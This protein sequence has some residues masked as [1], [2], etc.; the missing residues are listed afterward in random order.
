MAVANGGMH[1]IG[2]EIVN[3]VDHTA[4]ATLEDTGHEVVG[5]EYRADPIAMRLRILSDPLVHEQFLPRLPHLF[6]G[7]PVEPCR[8]MIGESP[9]EHYRDAA[10]D[11]RT[12]PTESKSSHG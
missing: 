8:K 5:V 6:A 3:I 2:D 4:D 10:P 12:S 11:C 7:S 1:F 9:D